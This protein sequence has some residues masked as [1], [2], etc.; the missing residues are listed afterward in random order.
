MFKSFFAED[1]TYEQ[2]NLHFSGKQLTRLREITGGGTV[3]IH[4]ALT[5]YI[6]LLLNTHCFKNDDERRILRTN[7]VINFR[8]VSDSIAPVGLVAN[9][10][11]VMSSDNFDDPLSLSSI[12]KTIRRS[13]DRARNPELLEKCVAT[14][15]GLLRKMA[16]EDLM[17]DLGPFPNDITVNSNFRYDWALLVDFGYTDK[18]RFHTLWTGRYYFRVFRLNPMK[19]G[20]EW[21]SRD[22][23]GAEVA[24]RIAKNIKDKFICAWQNDVAENFSN[25][26]L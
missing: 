15:D 12:A 13:I 22:R 3:T 11:L 20:R 23:D 19:N 24:F 26:K 21:L 6:V 25:I 18:C 5:S 9:A 1:E 4:D 17:S 16:R 8:G 10:V 7:T 2:L 14:A